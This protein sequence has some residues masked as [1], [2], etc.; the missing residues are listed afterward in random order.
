MQKILLNLHIIHARTYDNPRSTRT[1]QNH[2]FFIINVCPAIISDFLICHYLLTQHLYGIIN[3]IFI[4][5][6][7]GLDGS[8]SSS[9]TLTHIV[10][11]WMDARTFRV[12][13][14]W[15]HRSDLSIAEVGK[16]DQSH[17]NMILK[18]LS[19]I[20]VYGTRN[21]CYVGQDRGYKGRI[22]DIP[23]HFQQVL[24]SPLR[25]MKEIRYTA[26]SLAMFSLNMSC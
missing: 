17:G 7:S 12:Q 1:H 11:A 25:Q 13:C 5:G 8:H 23:S 20:Y 21:N 10:S 9:C 6:A 14:A 16:V 19:C 2:Q 18:K 3:C 26:C 15:L 4:T 24:E 22:H